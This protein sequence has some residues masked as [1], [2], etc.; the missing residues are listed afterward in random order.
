M[1]AYPEERVDGR[2]ARAERTRAAIVDAHL[3]LIGEGDLKPTG[4]RIAERAGVSLRALWTNFKDM[5]TLFEASGARVLAT[6]DAAFSPVPAGLPRAERIALY[7]RQRARLLQLIAAPARAAA[8]REP[9]SPQLRRNRQKH[10]ERLRDEVD[11]LFAEEFAL[12]GA[13]AP[14]LRDAVMAASMWPAWS[15]LRDGLALSAAEA[16]KVMTRT[17]TALLS[18]PSDG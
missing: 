6:Y 13:S 2:T 18:S 3:A 12:A 16:E 10:V 14:V 15:M 11:V 17:V 9:F 5:E 1:A 7:C 4:E 8:M